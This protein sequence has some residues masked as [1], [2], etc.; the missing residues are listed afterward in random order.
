MIAA[1]KKNKLTLRIHADA[2]LSG[3]A[4]MESAPDL[5]R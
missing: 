3:A 1:G 4:N 5:G 2:G